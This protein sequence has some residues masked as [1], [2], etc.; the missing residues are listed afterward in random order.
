[1]IKMTSKSIKLLSVFGTLIAMAMVVA[2]YV[3]KYANPLN[4]D[5]ELAK[6]GG[7]GQEI[8]KSL[9][10]Y[11]SQTLTGTTST[12]Q[13]SERTATEPTVITASSSPEDKQ[14]AEET[15][16]IKFPTNYMQPVELKLDDRRI[17]KFTDKNNL[18]YETRLIYEPG[19][20]KAPNEVLR[21]PFDRGAS[22]TAEREEKTDLPK[23]VRYK[24]DDGRKT[25]YYTYQK[26]LETSL[27]Q[28]KSWVYYEEGTGQER[29][30]YSFENVQLRLN[31]NGEVEGY[32]RGEQELKNEE[33]KSQVGNDL[34]ERA[35]LTLQKEA[36]EDIENGNHTPDFII[37]KPYF[38]DKD[39][40]RTNLDWKV[41][42]DKKSIS[43]EFTAAKERY[44]LA[45]DPTVQFT[46]PGQSTEGRA[47]DGAEFG[48]GFSEV[49]AAG[50]FNAD[51]KTDLAVGT[52][53]ANIYAGYVYIFYNNDGIAATT[54]AAAD[55]TIAGEQV[56]DMF[57][58]A[59]AS[60]DFNYDGKTD[61]AVTEGYHDSNRGAVHVF[62]NDG[63]YT[64]E[65]STSDLMITGQNTGD[66]FGTAL[67]AG[68]F[69]YDGRVDLAA[70]AQAYNTYTGRTYIFYNDGS[71]PTLAG[72]ANVI[73]TGQAVW[74]SF[75]AK[76][77][78]GDFNGDRRV[79]LAVSA[80]GYN[81]NTGR[82]YIFHNDGTIP[83]TAA[84]ADVTISGEAA[85]DY[86]GYAMA[87]GDF[88]ANGRTDLAIAS[89]YYASN[90]SGQAYIFYNDG[91]IPTTAAT[92]DVKIT[93]S[94]TTSFGSALSQGDF[95]GDG[96]VDLA[97]GADETAYIF[98]NDNSIATTATTADVIIYGEGASLFG[99][100]M[101][102][103]DFDADGKADLAVG[104]PGLNSGRAYI[105]YSNNGF[106]D[107]GKVVED[108]Y[109]TRSSG[110]SFGYAMVAGDFNSDG[111]TDLVVGAPTHT[112][113][114]GRAYIFYNDSSFQ[115]G[116]AEANLIITGEA[117][118][119]RFGNSF[120]VGDFNSDGKT[121]L[122]VGAYNY[123]SYTGRAYIFY[124]DGSIP[125]IA[126][127]ADKIITGEST[128]DY[129]S[130]SLLSED[131]NGDNKDDLVVGALTYNSAT[132]R[133]YVF[134]NDGTIP[135]S[136]ASADLIISGEGVSNNFGISLAACDINS[137]GKAD[138]IIGA[139]RYNTYT[140][141]VYVFYNDGTM[142]TSA[143]TADFIINGATTSQA[144][145]DRL[146]VG[147]LND[148]G[149][150]DLIVVAIQDTSYSG[151]IYIFYGSTT[152]P[153]V[154][155]SADL[156]IV[157]EA[158][159]WFGWALSTG[160]YNNDGR[161]DLAVGAFSRSSNQGGFYLIYGSTTMPTT[162]SSADVLI[163][164]DA[165]SRLGS[166]LASGDFN[167]DGTV[168]IAV[169]ADDQSFVLGRA[170]IFN[171]DGSMPTSTA[172]AD[173]IIYGEK[174]G[175]KENGFGS[176]FSAGDL[177]HDGKTDLVV[178]ATAYD[179]N[180][181]KIFVF[182]NDGKV[183]KNTATADAIIVGEATS[184]YFGRASAIGDFNAD[185]IADLSV[186]AFGYNFNTG[187][188]YIFYGDGLPLPSFA[189]SAD[190]IVAGQSGSSFGGTM[191]AGD[192]N[193]DGKTDLI[194][195]GIRYA[196]YAGRVYVFYGSTTLPMTA[197]TADM[198]ITGEG[199]IN[200]FSYDLELGDFNGDA[201]IDLAVGAN[202][203]SSNTGRAYIFY[204]S[205]TMPSVASAA[206][207]IITGESSSSDFGGALAADDLN[208]DGKDDLVVG[209]PMYLSSTGRVYV[210]YSSTTMP[211]TAST[212]DVIITGEAVSSHFGAGLSVG[213]FNADGRPDI[214]VSAYG[215]ASS[216]GRTYVFYNDGTMPALASSSD[217]FF[218]GAA[219]SDRFGY[220]MIAGNFD[221]SG[222]AV[223][224]V[225][226]PG[227]DYNQGAVY[228]FIT[229]HGWAHSETIH[230]NVK[231][232]GSVKM[233]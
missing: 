178:G 191:E 162:A 193:N 53:L 5:A 57:G 143:A 229:K 201:R 231:A 11:P 81:S 118:D 147:D 106:L 94:A 170:Y 216:T 154:A 132:G 2:F 220:S 55:V 149:R 233:W 87:A 39:S 113:S 196:T 46:A 165:G 18:Y 17:I 188:V 198:M 79:D 10:Q 105:F 186:G 140:G 155:S 206:D 102:A 148:D 152:M 167:A 224:V 187:R 72:S 125:S 100:S 31:K 30:E 214:A 161:D 176:F 109:D 40:K 197:S 177:N 36:G 210:F 145:G 183:A 34:F 35:R 101:A 115:S 58:M 38:L 13:Y 49:M 48:D 138:L 180:T 42:E 23:Y 175:S 190:L 121:D 65:A 56:N 173:T 151:R 15:R 202:R 119:S 28:I 135:T 37:P 217:V 89:P 12:Y 181:G 98:Y 150:S 73:I 130:Y 27:R 44:P 142:P 50:D 111:R 208:L 131:F 189:S 160:D 172:T 93:G 76:L 212:A 45:L 117:Q 54:T 64:A 169:G 139:D 195:G 16:D 3:G 47:I 66:Y 158:G 146:A 171:N 141:R 68:D 144:F 174:Y 123:N 52:P 43:V 207:V 84:T 137:D 182:Y 4:L 215:Y 19:E 127:S 83:T 116:A 21:P 136:A 211:T 103:G 51:G 88:D 59:I 185:G 192:L 213:D 24:S 41:S 153:T 133:A 60:G 99:V 71:I 90:N 7:L 70:S 120:A 228:Y 1:M 232:W 77:V 25:I 80:D 6:A 108:V 159:S 204:G 14:Q 86:F 218:T 134:Y 9:T 74:N 166:S 221:V 95:N 219:I 32:Y 223:L 8:K 33:A 112:T 124:C 194:V 75:G 227:F 122:V 91:S 22:G 126:A 205:T 184:G 62:Y 128:S 164:G 97:V 156:S 209:G 157:G 226:A 67:V 92:A 203:R 199:V 225:G 29:E 78:S 129:F 69:N 96:N 82:A 20:N 107:S 110:S 200:Q 114:T 85:D 61:L 104:A 179:D 26:R 63:S 222:Q 163:A 168:D 230:G